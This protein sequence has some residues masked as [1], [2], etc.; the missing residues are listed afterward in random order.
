MVKEGEKKDEGEEA[1][2]HTYLKDAGVS[3]LD[4]AFAPVRRGAFVAFCAITGGVG[5]LPR[6]RRTLTLYHN[7]GRRVSDRPL[8]R[9]NIKVL[10]LLG[11]SLPERR[12]DK[13]PGRRAVAGPFIQIG[14][15]GR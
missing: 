9:F 6:E 5:G 11:S 2:L 13:M 1:E 10:P 3:C 4:V 12:N 14:V 15:V 7:T 8:L